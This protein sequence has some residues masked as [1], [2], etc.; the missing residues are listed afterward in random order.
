MTEQLLVNSV[1]SSTT[2]TFGRALNSVGTHHF[3]IDGS[4]AP[5]EEITPVDAFLAGISACA[6]HMIERFANEAG[7][8]VERAEADIEGI[9]RAGDPARFE[10]IN[11]RLV[12]RGPNQ[13]QA[14]D[15]VQRFK[16]R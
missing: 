4:T 16:D 15:L 10:R 12:I 2:H 7:V 9:R 8:P 1:H 11:L 5:K 14:E 3:V 6:V 13:A